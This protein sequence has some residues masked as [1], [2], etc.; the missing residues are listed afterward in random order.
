MLFWNFQ[1][2]KFC[3]VKKINN[4]IEFRGECKYWACLSSLKC[5]SEL[6]SLT[7]LFFHIKN[8]LGFVDSIHSF[9]L[10]ILEQSLKLTFKS[11]STYAND[12]K[13]ILRIFFI[14]QKSITCISVRLCSSRYKI[15]ISWF[16]SYIMEMHMGKVLIKWVDLSKEFGCMCSTVVFN[17]FQLTGTWKISVAFCAPAW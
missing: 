5:T 16:T 14:S 17:L 8:L 11:N 2:S 4:L 1:C 12:C 6:S 7:F 3:R 10:L 15:S 13:I 9:Q